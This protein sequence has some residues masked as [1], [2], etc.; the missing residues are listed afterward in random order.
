MS[1]GLERAQTPLLT[2]LTQE[3]VDSDYQAAV[4]RRNSTA[5]ARK[6]RHLI[7][8]VVV[9]LFAGLATV[10]AQQTSRNADADEASRS[11]LIER[12]KA[13]RE[14]GTRLQARAD[15]LRESNADTEERVRSLGNRY[16]D[17]A[18]RR[19]E[20]AALT[21][22]D[23]VT[24]P[25]IRVTLNNSPY[26]GPNTVIRDADLALLADAL[27]AAGAEAISINGQRLTATTAIRNSGV[28]IEV[29]RIGIAPPYTVVAIGDRSTLAANLVE[30]GSGLQ[31]FALADQYGFTYQVD[32]VRRLRLPGAPAAR[33]NLRFAEALRNESLG[34]GNR[35]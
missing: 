4:Q 30:T 34:K 18:A 19:S 33:G 25:G 20:L 29:N 32:N 10:A 27:W 26:A 7:V 2:L 11:T 22:L 1:R 3:A 16:G 14:V 6:Q 8:L 15:T 13:R 28:P 24:G 21:G 17:A 31:F 35:P 9:A 23:P 12:I 5:Y